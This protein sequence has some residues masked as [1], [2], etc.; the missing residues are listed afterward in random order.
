VVTGVAHDL[1]VENGKLLLGGKL[2]VDNEEGG[3]K[4]GGL[5]GELRNGV[6]AVLEDSLVSIDE[7]D[8]RNAGDG[9]HEGGVVAASDFTFSILHS[10]EILA[11]DS[12]VSDFEFILLA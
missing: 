11:V 2:S 10:F 9:V 1:F 8:T 4:E 6:T 5:F 3:L 7:R 12:T